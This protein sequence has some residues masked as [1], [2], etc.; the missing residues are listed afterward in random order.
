MR[1]RGQRVVGGG[2]GGAIKQNRHQS[3][4][5]TIYCLVLQKHHS[6]NLK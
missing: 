2:G 1:W 5:L 3:N 6:Y 4:K